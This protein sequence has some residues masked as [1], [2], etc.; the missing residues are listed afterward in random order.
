LSSSFLTYQIWAGVF[1]KVCVLNL[2]LAA[3]KV[4][5]VEFNFIARTAAPDLKKDTIF[6]NSTF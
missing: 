4:T 6:V 2:K 1:E 5:G 3:T